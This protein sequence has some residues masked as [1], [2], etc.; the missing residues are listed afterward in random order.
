MARRKKSPIHVTLKAGVRKKKTLKQTITS[1]SSIKPLQNKRLMR[2][3]RT[4][5]VHCGYCY[6]LSH[7]WQKTNKRNKQTEIHE[8]MFYFWSEASMMINYTEIE[9][10]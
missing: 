3:M 9:T 7:P 5:H 1:T 8:L 10:K 6:T 2:P 4:E